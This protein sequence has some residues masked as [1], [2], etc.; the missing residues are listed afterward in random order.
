MGKVF[1]FLI[2]LLLWG[3]EKTYDN[4]IDSSNDDY[5]VTSIVGVK[6]SVDLKIPGDSLLAPRI[7]FSDESNINKVYFNVY[8]S[9]NSLLNGSP[10]EMEDLNNNR[11]EGQYILTDDNPNGNYT[12]KFSVTGFSGSSKLVATRH[13]YLNNGQDNFPPVI[14]NTVIDPDTVV[15]EQPTVILTS[16]EAA[17]S[18]GQGDISEVYFIVYKPDGTT[19]G[20]KIQLYDDG[21]SENGDVTAGDGIYSR[22]IQVDQSNQKGT[23]RFEFQA[24]DRLGALSNIINHLV[25]IQ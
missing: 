9:D 7:I 17:D 18:N 2:P 21:E 5:Q 16:V 14:S 3:C 19:N 15:V 1:L 23:Y 11:F 13:F 24:K 10:I 22:L 12:L 4:V 25:L 6:D 20:N 8:D